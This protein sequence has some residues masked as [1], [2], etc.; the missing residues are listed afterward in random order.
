MRRVTLGATGLAPSWLGLGTLTMGPL[1]RGLPPAA[2]AAVVLA[3][4]RA[5]IAF[6]DC[7]QMYGTYE[8]VSLALSQWHGERPVLASKTTAADAAGAR[9]AVREACAALGVPALDLFLLHM[10][11]DEAD[12]ARREPALAE[13]HACKRE[14]LVR[15]VGATSHSVPMVARLAD[16]PRLDVLHPIVNRDGL[17]VLGGTLDGQLQALARARARGAGVYAMKPLGGGRLGAVAGEAFAWLA[18]RPEIDAVVVGMTSADEVAVNVALAQGAAPDPA[19]LAA[20]GAQRRRIFV[21]RSLC[22]GCGRCQAFCEH[23]A[24]ALDETGKARPDHDRCVV[25]GYCMPGCPCF[26]LRII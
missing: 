14:G 24:I 2:G 20:V 26:A 11:R 9:A 22:S 12:L 15:A 23:G 4:L 8:H 21:N 16:D 25:C 5:G 1:Q 10:V 7:A 18:G 19:Q 13:L 6:I 3:A 17:G